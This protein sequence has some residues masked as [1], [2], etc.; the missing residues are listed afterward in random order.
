MLREKKI[1]G[2]KISRGKS[3]GTPEGGERPKRGAKRKKASGGL[4]NGNVVPAF[5]KNQKNTKESFQGEMVERQHGEVNPAGDGRR[6]PSQGGKQQHKKDCSSGEGT[7]SGRKKNYQEAP[8]DTGCLEENTGDEGGPTR[9]ASGTEKDKK[10]RSRR[11]NK[12]REKPRWC[13][14]KRCPEPTFQGKRDR[15]PIQVTKKNEPSTQDKD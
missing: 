1:K 9:Q 15:P 2:R 11:I 5:L 12:G 4:S 8:V 14:R 13:R 6:F 10:N 7:R 3:G